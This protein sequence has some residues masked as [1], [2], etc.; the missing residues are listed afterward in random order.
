[1]AGIPKQFV[2]PKTVDGA[3]EEML[4]ATR[5]E[6]NA[7]SR[8]VIVSALIWEARHTDGDALGVIIRGYLREVQSNSS[9]Q[10]EAVGR[11]GPRPFITE[12]T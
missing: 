11:P 5:R 6:G 2:L 3:L 8:S 10:S 12:G 1:M 9:P 7:V 4:R